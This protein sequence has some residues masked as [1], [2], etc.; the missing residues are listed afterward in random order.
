[1]AVRA[2]YVAL[3]AALLWLSRF[4][5]ASPE[6]REIV[7]AAAVVWWVIALVWIAFAPQRVTSLL[8]GLAGLLAL[9]PAW[10]ALLRFPRGT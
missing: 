3:V 1:M 8:A 10:L 4:V 2:L 5:T 7:L 6:G 9:V